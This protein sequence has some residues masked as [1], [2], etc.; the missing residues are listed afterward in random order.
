MQI[1]VI[2]CQ[3]LAKVNP[4]KHQNVSAS[5]DECQSSNQW[6]NK[7]F[8]MQVKLYDYYWFQVAS[9]KKCLVAFVRCEWT[10]SQRLAEDDPEVADIVR[11]EKARQKTGLELIASEV[12][13]FYVKII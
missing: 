2:K 9:S 8:V 4:S 5:A 10:G 12:I 11:K 3:S 13:L 7:V 6:N 1:D